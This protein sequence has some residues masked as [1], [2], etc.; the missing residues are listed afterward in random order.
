MALP[1]GAQAAAPLVLTQD[2][3]QVDAW[4]AITLKADPTYQ[5]SVQDML[6]R[7]DQFEAP[8]RRGGSL[9][10]HKAAMWLHIPIIAP[11]ALS[12]PWVVDVGFSSLH[13]EIYLAS[14]G[15]VIQQVRTS[16]PGQTQLS[17]RT[18]AMAF[19]LRA[20][21]PYD[22]LIR[23]QATGPL[24]LPITVSEMPHQM[25]QALGEQM[26]QGLLNGLALCLLV[27][28]LIQW[29]TQR[30]P[31]FGFYALVVLG[32]TGFSLQ[33]FGIGA[34]FL[35]PGN[36]WMGRYAGLAAGLT[37]LAGSFLFLGHTL[38]DNTQSSRYARTMQAGAAITAVV[39][40][41]VMLGGLSV[42]IAIVY[43]SLVGPLPS[44][45]S[46]PA[47]IVRVRQ[48]D[49]IGTTLLVA[50]VA[51][52]VAAAVMVCLVQ[53]W[54]PA[55]FWTLHSFQFG[56]TVDM[57]LFFRV[58]GL[59][60]KAVQAKALE[61]I[62]ER[63]L[64]HSLAHTDPLTGLSNRRGLQH[65][66]HAALAQCSPQ[67]MVAVYLMD[68]DGFKPVND[69][70]G[71]DV[72]DDLLVAVGQRLQSH[73][74]HQ[75]DLVARLGGDEFIVMA[76][77]LAT[78]HQADELGRSLL[79]AFER[80]FML[81]HLSIRVGLTIG[82]ALAPLDS[83]DAQ[84]LIR[85][86]DAAMYAGKGGA[87]TPSAATRANWRSH[88]DPRAPLRPLAPAD[89]RCPMGPGLLSAGG[90][91]ADAGRT[92][93]ARHGCASGAARRPALHRCL[94]CRVHARRSVGHPAGR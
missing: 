49:A 33:F 36:P 79:Q 28:S 73:V 32:S 69:A 76:R 60:A 86:A 85:L 24:I 42:P 26:L 21:Q 16:Q 74:R 84:H 75:T 78:P 44:L 56:A 27:Y 46:L 93:P 68:L 83:D 67:R 53:G 29:V 15:Q 17:S 90:G 64:M 39:C 57:L 5:L 6:G 82:Y 11:K 12:T 3:P 20:G 8:T 41:A 22:L 87:N 81:S 94:A 9:G 65:A 40:A 88:H 66:L 10:V 59:R 45:I 55:N 7:L 63:D 92:G 31:M 61:A 70:H 35:W 19:D 13:A 50:W 23:V 89:P 51:F 77:D 71:H 34:Q 38:A 72:G 58:L 80:P 30:E 18:P 52:G 48:K 37:A 43:M 91:V 2:S 47:A 25:R 62:R 1:L 54:V 4:Q 14:G